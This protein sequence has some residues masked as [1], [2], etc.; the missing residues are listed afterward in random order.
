MRVTRYFFFFFS[1]DRRR[2]C[3]TQLMC[4]YTRYTLSTNFSFFCSNSYMD[5]VISALPLLCQWQQQLLIQ[6]RFFFGG[7]KPPVARCWKPSRS[8]GLQQQQQYFLLLLLFFFIFEVYRSNDDQS[9]PSAPIIHHPLSKEFK[10]ERGGQNSC[11][12]IKDRKYN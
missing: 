9:D 1:F 5:D 12:S 8:I 4:C 10:I 3:S 6:F 2:R 7:Y 11:T